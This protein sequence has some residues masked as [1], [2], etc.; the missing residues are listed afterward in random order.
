MARGLA[1]AQVSRT[2]G[3]VQRSRLGIILSLA[4]VS[5]SLASSLSLIIAGFE[6]QLPQFAGLDYRVIQIGLVLLVVAFAAYTFSRDRRLRRLH[7]ELVEEKVGAARLA[8]RISTLRHVE[9]ERDILEG[10]L[11]SSADGTLV[12]D[13]QRRVVRTNPA[14]LSLTGSNGPAMGRRCDEVLGCS[15]PG[16][17]ACGDRCPFS[18]VLESEDAVLDHTFDLR[19]RWVSGAYAPIRGRDGRLAFV[20]G[21]L[22]D[23]TRAKEMEQLQHDFV[24]IIS[25]EL[26]GPLTAVKGFVT[27][28]L[29]QETR[30][31]PDARREF[32][33]TINDQA[34]RLND[35]VDDLLSVS[36]IESRRLHMKLEAFDLEPLAR[37]VL[38]G[39]RGKW[40]DRD[41]VL[42]APTDLS[43]VHA[44]GARISQ[45]LVNLV[46]NAV[47]Y[48]PAGGPVRVCLSETEEDVAVAV[49]DSGIGIAPEDA[50]RL[51]EKFNRISTPETRDIGGT[52]LGLYIVKSIVEAHGGRIFL[53]SAP[54]VGSTFTFELPKAPRSTAAS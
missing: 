4:V 40:G 49:E 12:V 50:A 51:F 42:E 6:D 35:L 10:V 33:R 20:I 26:R 17:L 25:H 15:R 34:D 3:A 41:I 47:K 29:R 21:S 18:E 48:S 32:L 9:T 43:P 22:R 19:G 1:P 11:S 16:G 30:L 44:D 28:L 53:S 8:E 38:D 14:L 23:V 5:I 7:D 27:T 36:R 46:D 37:K 31:P 39:M 45:V 13:R 24:S 54:G 2:E 52:G